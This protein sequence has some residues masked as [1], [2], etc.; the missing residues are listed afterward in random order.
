MLYII[1]RANLEAHKFMTNHNLTLNDCLIAKK[2][3]DLIDVYNEN[4]VICLPVPITY[5]LVMK[6]ILK[7]NNMHNVTKFYNNR[8]IN[9]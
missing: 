4:Y 5:K 3:M 2:V 8:L 7:L 6:P 1:T 9:F